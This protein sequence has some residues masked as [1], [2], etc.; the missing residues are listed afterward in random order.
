RDWMGVI[1]LVAIH[2]RALTP[3]QIMQNFE[4]GVGEK[5]YLMF[6]VSHLV[7]VP[8]SYVVFEAS[9]FDSYAYLF[10]EP[11]FLSLDE[12]A[13]PNNIELRG[14]RIALNGAEVPVGQTYAR[15]DTVIS[16]AEYSPDVGQILTRLGAVLPL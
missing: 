10:R 1:R 6:S 5:F 9:Q 2:K 8:Q 11:F 13:Q 12:N 16:S 3:E 14:M 4:A 15:L 7:D